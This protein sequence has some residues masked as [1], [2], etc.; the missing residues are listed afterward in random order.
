[1]I[2]GSSV[3]SY[4]F[5]PT[6][7]LKQNNT[8]YFDLFDTQEKIHLFNSINLTLLEFLLDRSI[9]SN[10]NEFKSFFSDEEIIANL[11]SMDFHL[12][13]ILIDGIINNNHLKELKKLKGNNHDILVAFKNKYAPCTSHFSFY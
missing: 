8:I 13:S 10:H 7:K 12:L 2:G 1:M 6:K 4:K 3:L 11:N 9:I 5:L